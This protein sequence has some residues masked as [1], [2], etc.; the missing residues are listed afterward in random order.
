MG[1]ESSTLLLQAEF[2][3][4]P[5]EFQGKGCPT[6]ESPPSA[7]FLMV[8]AIGHISSAILQ[9]SKIMLLEMTGAVCGAA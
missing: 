7:T 5:F 9:F 4:P 3:A 8:I 6:G 1:Y 2:H